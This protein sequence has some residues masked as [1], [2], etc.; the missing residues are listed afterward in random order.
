MHTKI[1]VTVYAKKLRA[2]RDELKKQHEKD[3]A[4]YKGSFATW[5]LALEKWIKDNASPRI[6]QINVAEIQ[7]CES[8]GHY[9]SSDNAGFRTGSFF[10]GAPKPPTYPKNKCIREIDNLP[11]HLAIT[12]QT[13]V[14]VS[15]E[16]VARYLGDGDGR[17]G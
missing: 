17:E 7:A 8:R 3:L 9:S 13:T 2:K 14:S 16:D 4:S 10:A 1:K 6:K 5:K 15:T 12:G 11:R